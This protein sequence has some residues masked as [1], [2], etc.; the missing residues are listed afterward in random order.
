MS[1]S[2]ALDLSSTNSSGSTVELGAEDKPS[3]GKG[4]EQLLLEDETIDDAELLS[5]VYRLFIFVT[6]TRRFPTFCVP[7]WKV[8]NTKRQHKSGGVYDFGSVWCSHAQPCTRRRFSKCSP[9]IYFQISP[10][11]YPAH[12]PFA[13]LFLFLHSSSDLPIDITSESSLLEIVIALP[14]LIDMRYYTTQPTCIGDSEGIEVDIGEEMVPINQNCS[15]SA[16]F[17]FVFMC[18]LFLG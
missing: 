1:D 7:N 5:S 12:N 9:L 6:T 8:H 17:F 15:M 3:D 14:A 10:Y 16:Y 11:L 18:F 4:I 2:D 13:F